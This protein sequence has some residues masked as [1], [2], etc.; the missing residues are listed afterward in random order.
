MA[1]FD[2]YMTNYFNRTSQGAVPPTP[3]RAVPGV[4]FGY[5]APPAA[6]QP[7]A[8]PP[9]GV[10]VSADGTTVGDHEYWKPWEKF[11]TGQY[12]SW[13]IVGGGGSPLIFAGHADRS[14]ADQKLLADAK[15]TGVQT[16][17]LPGTTAA[18]IANVKS[19]AAQRVAMTREIPLDS[20][21]N[22]GYVGAQT[23]LTGASAAE[24]RSATRSRD[25]GVLVEPPQESAA[26]KI[27]R[28]QGLGMLPK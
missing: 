28:L 7:P 9:Q 15:L 1:G 17:L 10:S 13:D 23:G 26:S 21:A 25:R 20:A 19:Q 27:F 2:D 24:T 11:G 12:R 4:G 3:T 5:N 18:D 22:R 14:A 16:E 6:A 8:A